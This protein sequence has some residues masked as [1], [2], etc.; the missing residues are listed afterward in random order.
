MPD[1]DQS[2]LP[3]SDARPGPD[4]G[5]VPGAA[6]RRALRRAVIGGGA[7]AALALGGVGIAAATTTTTAPS[8]P[9]T[10]P[11][12]AFPGGGFFGR[13][14]GRGQAGGFG[15]G[16][17]G[18]GT[19]GGGGLAAVPATSGGQKVTA[20]G[21]GTLTVS[22]PGGRTTTYATTSATTYTVDGL[23]ATA[24]AV[25]VGDRVTVRVP[26]SPG[27]FWGGGTSSTTTTTAPATPTALTVN[28]VLPELA[29]TVHT[30]GHGQFVLVDS[31]G[32]WRTVKTTAGTAYLQAGETAGA[33][34]LTVGSQV[35][36][37]GTVDADHTA[38]DASRVNVVLPTVTGKV[39]A[40]S[41]TAFTVSTFARTTVTV[42]TT[43][44]TRFTAAG[45]T[46]SL[47]DVKVGSVVSASG[48]RAADGT[49]TAVTVVVGGTERRGA[50]GGFGFPGGAGARTGPSGPPSGSASTA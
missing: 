17:L 31:Q 47:S 3:G 36:A 12:P 8:T 37:V 50:A 28:V 27:H 20:V 9:S 16:A 1:D 33:T 41:G 21:H 18:G 11:R 5:P 6:R 29:G 40:V 4:G 30:V 25:A 35:E 32:F 24:S 13:V 19:F 45:T 23:A 34:A 46:G 48:T 2:T 39:T 10:A 22:G 42:D 26:F 49:V 38:L 15:P 14:G 43:S 7:V 44:T